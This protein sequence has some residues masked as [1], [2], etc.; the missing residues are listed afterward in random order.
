MKENNR[1]KIFQIA[2]TE[3]SGSTMLDMMLANTQYGFSC[4]EIFAMFRPFRPH[5]FKPQCGCRYVGCKF[6][7]RV[8]NYGENRVYEG[9]FNEAH[10]VDY[11]LDSSKDLVWF[12]DQEHYQKNTNYEIIRIVLW[13]DPLEYAYSCWKR[14]KINNWE[15][16]WVNY[17]SRLFSISPSW[18]AL[19]FRDLVTKPSEIL[20]ALCKVIGIRYFPGLEQFWNKTHHTLFGSDS[21]KAHVLQKNSEEYEFLQS[22]REKAKPNISSDNIVEFRKHRSIY[23]EN[24]Y[25]N[26]LPTE[27]RRSAHENHLIRDVKNILLKSSF[28]YSQDEINFRSLGSELNPGWIWYWKS[29]LWNK[30]IRLNLTKM[31]N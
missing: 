26:K 20:S 1:K 31:A 3:F 8:I 14:G 18:Y 12:K 27:I 11:L 19:R 25:Y 23:Y 24:D 28:Q 2:S 15:N 7:D 16:R 17:Y 6:W 30:V 9:I 21:T 22:K 29:K 4:G 5:H 13:K 10:Q